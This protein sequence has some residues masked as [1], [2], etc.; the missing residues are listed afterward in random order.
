[1]LGYSDSGKD[2]GFVASQWALHVAQERLAR[3][4]GAST[5]LELELFHGR[6][7]STVARRR[8]ARTARSSP[9]RAGRRTGGSGSPSRARRSRPA[10]A[11]PSSRCARS[12]RRSSAVLLASRAGEPPVPEAW[13]AEMDADRRRARASA[14][15]R[16][17]TTTPDFAALLRAGH[18]DR[19]ADRLNI[20]SRPPSRAGD[21]GD[22]GAARDPV[23]VRLDAEPAAAAVLVRRGRRAGGGRPRA[24]ARDGERWPFFREPG[25][26]RSRWRCSR[27]TS[28]SPSATCGSSTPTLRERFWPRIARE[29]DRVV[30]AVLEITGATALLDDTPAL[31]RRLSH[32]NPWVDPLSHLQVELLERAAR[33]A[34]R[35]ARRRCWRRSPGSPRGCATRAERR[36]AQQPPHRQLE[37]LGAAAS[38]VLGGHDP[39]K[40]GTYRRLPLV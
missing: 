13:R 5:G 11:T 21:G 36:S 1:M 38:V 28:A 35:G 2:S 7:G 30:G 37:H 4:G 20:G 12:S 16:S 25:L 18:A 3:A 15:A 6:G 23:G 31:Q 17:S 39:D 10:T 32:R 34:S 29:Y 8:A 26:A 19:R 24:P 27:P 14:T 40:P 9:S 22:R 33:R